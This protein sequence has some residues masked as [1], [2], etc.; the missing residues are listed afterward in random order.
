MHLTFKHSICPTHG[1]KP[2]H[3]SSKIHIQGQQTHHK[4]VASIKHLIKHIQLFKPSI[5]VFINQG[6]QLSYSK[7]HVRIHMHDL[8]SLMSLHHNTYASMHVQVLMNI[9]VVHP[10]INPNYQFNNQSI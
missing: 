1:I 7:I 4:I 8:P 5:M 9:H 2:Y 3:S 10:S 6:D